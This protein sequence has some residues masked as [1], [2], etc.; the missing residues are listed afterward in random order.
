[1]GKT[2]AICVVGG[3]AAGMMAAAAAARLQGSSD[4]LLL[5]SQSR[6]GKKLLA[7]G[8][9]RCNFSHREANDPAR[10]HSGC[11]DTAAGV[12]RRF[13][14]ADT[15]R[16]FEEIGIP[17]WEEDGRLYP[18]SLQAGAVTDAL[19]FECARLGVEVRCQTPVRRVTRENGI[20]IAEDARALR[21][22]VATG[23]MASP[24]LGSD[25]SGYA[26]LEAFGHRRTPL[27]PALTQLVT[28]KPAIKGLSGLRLW[29]EGT[30]YIDGGIARR[31]CEELLFTDYG[32]SGPL[33]LALS[34]WASETLCEASA[35]NGQEIRVEV[36]LFPDM[37][38]EAL[39]AH[40]QSRI[41]RV[42]ER[43]LEELFLGLLHKR[44]GLAL[45][46]VA[47]L[48]PAAPNGSLGFADI[49]TLTRSAKAYPITITGT[50]GFTDAQVTCGGAAL[51]EFYPDTLE[52]RLSPGLY[53]CGEVL[54]VDGDCGGF[55]LQWAWSSG[56]VA[57]QSAA[58][59]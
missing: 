29:A 18:Y 8:G 33:A 4:I 32:L 25:G 38:A 12:L 59:R 21:L 51:S 9:G 55:N 7:T 41:A 10:Y 34:R 23:G 6:V 22:I 35:G 1:M 37:E 45:L 28:E 47:G 2:Y 26:L 53:A 40:L 27:F 39:R 46:R 57:G 11:P 54:D 48:S 52:S 5:E 13:T 3:G 19:R 36:N 43:P 58:S 20:Y 16:F 50:R 42:P 14:P 56:A 15:L 31:E 44:L 24:A 17:A 49:G 30:L